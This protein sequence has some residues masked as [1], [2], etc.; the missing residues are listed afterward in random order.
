MRPNLILSLLLALLFASHP[1]G[2]QHTTGLV[3][4]R[5]LGSSSNAFSTTR[6]EQNQVFADNQ[7]QTVGF[8][9]RQNNT[10]FGGSSG[11]LRADFSFNAGMVWT[12]DVG[13]LNP[14]LLQTARFPMGCLFMP[15]GETNPDSLRLVWFAP[16][17]NAAG[18]RWDG[19]ATGVSTP[20]VASS[21]TEN[22]VFQGRKG[23]LPGGLCMGEPG[24]FWTVAQRT[25]GAA[26][27]ITLDSMFVYRGD[28]NPSTRDVEWQ[29]AH[30]L[31]MPHC[32]TFDGQPY[33]DA[34]NIA[35]SPDGLSGWISAV[36]DLVGGQDSL[37]QPL[38]AHTSDGGATWSPFVEVS[39]TA[40]P[41]LLDS[42]NTFEVFDTLSGT[43]VPAGSG[44]PM[45]GFEADLVVDANG[46]PHFFT[47]LGNGENYGLQQNLWKG[48]YDLTSPDGG[49]TWELH[50][51]SPVLA[52]R[53]AFG[54]DLGPSGDFIYMD[55]YLQASRNEAGDYLFFT[56]TDTDTSFTGFQNP[57]NELPDLRMAGYRITD[58]YRTC[59]H[60]LTEGD[61][62]WGS[63]ML[64]PT[65]AP[66][67]LSV[68][69]SAAAADSC[70][71]L[72]LVFTSMPSNNQFEV[73]NFYYLG[74]DATFSASDFVDPATLGSGW[75]ASC[76]VNV[77]SFT[78]LQ[79][80]SELRDAR[81]WP[82]PT[83]GMVTV[84]ALS[85]GSW[86]CKLLDLTGRMLWQAQGEA[87]SSGEQLTLQ[88]PQQPNG[89]YLLRLENQD[90]LG[91]FRI[92]ILH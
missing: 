13:E 45:T 32:R 25:D 5:A 51:I 73:A 28:W 39:L 62:L 71:R 86:N 44:K 56:W 43:W 10:F 90:H 24:V 89:T 11:N 78:A 35:F 15:P 23:H 46:N 16:A 53:G 2:A 36:G 41:S 33:L 75:Y 40:F 74:N 77:C 17:Q 83:D 82:N 48:A 26:S 42:I 80:P 27:P 63:Q 31:H 47:L 38:L 49:A 12:N 70:F 69:H 58:G 4:V 67:V 6:M 1:L 52:H 50:L 54:T 76:S 8:I 7:T 92:Q 91:V 20:A 65:L 81:I 64:W 3:A 30:V 59:N 88:L 85:P 19:Y 66:I 22:Y 29:I 79:D 87:T 14:A 68:P 57:S 21:G 9:H 18:D 37:Y 61:I 60:N 72:P 84:E 34:V 55:N